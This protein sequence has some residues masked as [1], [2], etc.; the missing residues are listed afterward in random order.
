MRRLLAAAIVLAAPVAVRAQDPKALEQAETMLFVLKLYDKESGGFKVEPTGKP[1][2]R[3]VNGASKTLKYLGGRIPAATKEKVTEFVQK[4]YDPATG[5]FAE[6][7]GKPDVAM[8]AV[9]I[10]TAVEVD[11]P[12]DK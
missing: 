5:G 4:C 12:E 7:G 6:P 9:G 11:I 8:T 10:I 1:S 2:L 3:A